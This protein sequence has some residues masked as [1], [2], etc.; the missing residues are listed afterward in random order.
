MSKL[1]E[2]FQWVDDKNSEQLAPAKLEEVGQEAAVS[3]D[4]KTVRISR[5]KNRRTKLRVAM[6]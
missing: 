6:A 3:A 5:F 2:Y 1:L 4:L